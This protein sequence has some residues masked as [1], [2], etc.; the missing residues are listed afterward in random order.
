MPDSS[1]PAGEMEENAGYP[2]EAK[3]SS[4]ATLPVVGYASVWAANTFRALTNRNYRLYWIG[5]VISQSGSWMQSVAQGWLVL[6]LTGS[7]FVLGLISAMP[8]IPA[9]SL[10]LLGGV[11]A[12][13]FPKRRL[14]Q[15]TQTALL[16]L[17][18]I[19]AIL[20]LTGRIQIWQIALIVLGF[21][22]A[23]AFDQ[24]A[25]QAFVVELVGK[26]DLLN[27]IALNS[28]AFNLTRIVGPSIAGI[29][30]SIFGPGWCFL[31]NSLSFVGPVAALQ[32][33]DVPDTVVHQQ[34]TSVLQN[35]REGLSFSNHEP[36][37]RLQLILALIPSVFGFPY[38]TMMPVFANDVLHVGSSGLGL[39]M[40]FVGIGA[41]S[42]ALTLASAGE[43]RSRGM[44]MIVGLIIFAFAIITFSISRVFPLSLACLVLG[45]WAIITYSAT[46]NTLLQ[47][48]VPD[49][50]RGRVMSLNAMIGMGFTPLGS[51][52]IG[53]I[54]EFAGAPWAVAI[55]AAICGLTGLFVLIRIPRLRS[56]R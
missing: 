48:Q 47:T 39:M 40:A 21:G 36:N 53:T 43:R 18:G 54:A 41:L 44:M 3:Q 10:S 52:L 28:T 55:G 1:V 42:G 56:M 20:T 33:M 16:I 12:D 2:D 19:M 49:E 6:I 4:S 25:R 46:N 32:A 9:I 17:S 7:P 30:L 24:P 5:N 27:A 13:R 45:G 11:A 29:L 14:M 15:V 22:I 34:G 51:L 37:I 50:Y 35:L 8:A 38:I 31:I 26:K 23:N